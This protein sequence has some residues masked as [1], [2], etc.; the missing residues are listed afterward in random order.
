MFFQLI[1]KKKEQEFQPSII[2][3]IVTT[4]LLILA[5]L[6]LLLWAGLSSQGMMRLSLILAALSVLTM[7]P[8]AFLLCAR[9]GFLGTRLR[10]F[11]MRN[12]QPQAEGTHR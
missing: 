3:H 12:G 2:I 1:E 6:V 7:I 8:C 11:C 10:K 9:L 5:L 4:M